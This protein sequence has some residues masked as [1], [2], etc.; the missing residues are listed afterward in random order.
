MRAALWTRPTARRRC[1]TTLMSRC[2]GMTS[3]PKWTSMSLPALQPAVQGKGITD[4]RSK[5]F[6]SCM[7]FIAA[8]RPRCFCLREVQGGVALPEDGAQ[9]PGQ[10]PQV[11][12]HQR[13]RPG[14]PTPRPRT[15]VDGVRRD[16][17][18]TTFRFP[19]AILAE[20]M[21]HFWD[22]GLTLY[23]WGRSRCRRSRTR[24]RSSTEPTTSSRRS[25]RSHARST[26]VWRR[27]P[28]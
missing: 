19:D 9:E 4:P 13:E 6:S 7:A 23:C 21:D 10:Q 16:I 26:Y 8:Q 25:A 28:A 15:Y 12:N 18:A 20:S 11:Q 1:L 14:H 27:V 22:D 5:A 17:K 3:H 2:D 24:R